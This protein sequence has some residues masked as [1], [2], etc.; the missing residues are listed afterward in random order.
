MKIAVVIVNYNGSSCISSCIA[1]C[2]ADGIAASN[3]AV[4]D[5]G[6]HDD[7]IIRVQSD[8]PEI[9]VV[10][11][12]CNM[13]F[14]R[15]VNQ[16]IHELDQDLVLIL[17]NDACLQLGA[18]QSLIRCAKKFSNAALIGARLVDQ[19][20]RP[21]NVVAPFPNVWRDLIPRFLQKFFLP[22]GQIGRLA[23]VLEP[24]S[25]PTLIGAAL[26][27]R[28]SALPRLGLMDEDFFFYLE[29]TEWCYRAHNLGFEVMLCPEAVV[30]HEL[31]GTANRFRAASRIEFHR[32]RLLYAQKVEG[33]TPWLMLSAFYYFSSSINLLIN[34]L[35]VIL[36]LFLIPRLRYKVEMYAKV[37]LWHM[38]GRP[39]SWGLP[40]KCPRLGDD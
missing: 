23:E 20:L 24:V 35:G 9:R 27:L 28:R 14:A 1:S 36:T 13:G 37:W 2:V 38:L 18:S 5:N 12:T 40:N 39:Q 17:N 31:G 4:V 32:S 33:K 22:Q 3:I 21:Q 19:D 15:A 25:V 30:V 34:G 6:S 7:S 10:A 29:E 8:F 16:G 26:L 11:N